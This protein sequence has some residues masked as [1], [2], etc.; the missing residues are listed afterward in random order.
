MSRLQQGGLAVP[1][2]VSVLGFDNL[3]MSAHVTP[4]LTTV[5]QHVEPMMKT[6]VELLAADV[7][8]PGV[9]EA[10]LRVI[11]PLLVTRESTGL[12]PVT[13]LRDQR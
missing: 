10:P 3:D 12:A 8:E 13:V 1:G 2:D 5:D 7:A 6:A 11:S 9:G 4:L